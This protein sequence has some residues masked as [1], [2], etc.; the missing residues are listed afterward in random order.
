MALVGQNNMELLQ[1]EAEVM[2]YERLF[3]YADSLT[4]R[5]KVGQMSEEVVEIAKTLDKGRPVEYFLTAV[6]MMDKGR[7]NDAS[8]LYY[9]GDLR[10]RFYNSVNPKYSESHDGALLASFQNALG[11]PIGYYLRSNADNF[12]LVLKKCSEYHLTNDYK[13]YPKKKD[14][15]KFKKEAET[16]NNVI[17]DVEANK[18]KYQET[19][20]KQ[21]REFETNLNN[22]LE[23]TKEK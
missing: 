14:P 2:I 4:I 16:L 17:I 5:G 10:Y 13:F 7:Y 21:R 8:F 11:E 22:I 6:K 19:W 20:G 1:L 15:T 23:Q 9:L 3:N 12:I 18:V